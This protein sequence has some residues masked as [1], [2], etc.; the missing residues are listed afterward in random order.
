MRLSWLEA[1]DTDRPCAAADLETAGVFYRHLSTDPLRYEPAIEELKS[2]RGYIAR[3]E[4]RLSPET[5]N[6]DAVLGKFVAEHLHTDDEVRFVLSGEGIF[7]IRS[8]EDR[9]MRVVVEPGDFLVVPK[10]R[11]HRFLLTDKKAIHCVRLFQDQSGWVP[12]YRAA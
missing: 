3:D 7:D 1:S 5:P 9:W 2:S 11:H 6:L 8:V 4:V 10:N 12:V